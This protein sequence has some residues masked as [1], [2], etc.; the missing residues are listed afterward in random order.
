VVTRHDGE[1]RLADW[2]CGRGITASGPDLGFPRPLV[3]ETLNQRTGSPRCPAQPL[4]GN[5]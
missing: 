5:S 2:F 1:L 4:D 3:E